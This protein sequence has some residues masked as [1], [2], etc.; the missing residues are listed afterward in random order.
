MRQA[1]RVRVVKGKHKGA[2]GVAYGLDPGSGWPLVDF[3]PKSPHLAGQLY[4]KVD[5]RTLTTDD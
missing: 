5:P 4:V 2:F 3:D 1:T